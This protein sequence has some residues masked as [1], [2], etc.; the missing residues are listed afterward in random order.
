MIAS[1]L[2]LKIVY[3]LPLNAVTLIYYLKLNVFSIT[4]LERVKLENNILIGTFISLFVKLK[5]FHIIDKFFI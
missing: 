3:I 4:A 1:I 2:N 5:Q